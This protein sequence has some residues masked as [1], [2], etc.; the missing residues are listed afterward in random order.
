ML[1]VEIG[2][3]VIGAGLLALGYR[4][5]QRDVMVAAALVMFVSSMAGDFLEGFHEGYAY[6]AP[7]PAPAPKVS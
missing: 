4:K 7:I 2:L 5:N 1:Y 6:A 3:F